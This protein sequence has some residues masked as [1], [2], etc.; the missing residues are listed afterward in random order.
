MVKSGGGEFLHFLKII[1]KET[2]CN[3]A[4]ILV[5]PSEVIK[6]PQHYLQCCGVLIKSNIFIIINL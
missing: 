2:K 1:R 5:L 4:K 6:L 3:M